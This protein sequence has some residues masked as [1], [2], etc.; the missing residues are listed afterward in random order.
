MC[1]FDPLKNITFT[2][3]D[4]LDEKG[5]TALY[6]QYAYARVQSIFRRG[7]YT[8]VA[9]AVGEAPWDGADAALLE[10]AREQAL[11]RLIAR[12]PQVVEHVLDNLAI[13]TLAD[14]AHE[15]AETFSLFYEACPILRSDVSPELRA[16][17]LALAQTTA[18]TMRNVAALLGIDLP[19]RL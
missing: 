11:L 8:D 6:M 10:H 9:Y 16:A 18:R 12:L 2:I 3:E 5:T 15:L 4:V 1:R 17:R 13:H 14:Y 19:E 7:G